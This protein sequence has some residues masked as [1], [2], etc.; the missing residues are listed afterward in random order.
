MCL[1]FR[2]FR[3]WGLGCRVFRVFRVKGV[4]IR[5]KGLGLEVLGC[6]FGAEP[7]QSLH[8]PCTGNPSTPQPLNPQ[9]PI[10][11]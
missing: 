9:I 4:G 1:G 7:F 3:A 8:K 11:L 2:D 6:R 5:V 10:N